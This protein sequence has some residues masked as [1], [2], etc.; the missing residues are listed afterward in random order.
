MYTKFSIEEIKEKLK[1]TLSEE[2]YWHS[3]GTM[4]KAMELAERFGCD[5]EK[6][7]IA[8]LL[9]DC[10]KCLSK[11]ELNEY[12]E[13][14]E[15][16]EKLSTKTWHAPCGACLCEKEFGIEDNEI[17]SAIRWHTIG[18]KGMTNFEKIIFL[19][20]K[21]ENRTREIEFREKIEKVLD[22]TN[23]LD[24]AMLKSF[25]I[26]IKSLLKR[27]LPICFQTIDVYNDLLNCLN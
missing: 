19:A 5:I 3:I 18:K 26:T 4:E 23:N 21:I 2:R 7:Q 12:Q 1:N 20:D 25:K 27:K 10:A 22:K 24:S 11:E 9:H 15:D 17:L 14:F 13:Y 6:A 8:G 16:C